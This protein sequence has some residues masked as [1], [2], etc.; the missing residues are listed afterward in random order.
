M[1][2]TIITILLAS[3]ALV[4]CTKEHQKTCRFTGSKRD[5]TYIQ[6][7]F[8]V[9]YLYLGDKDSTEVKVDSTTFTSSQQYAQI[10][11]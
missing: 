10:C 1:K 4:S 7:D 8:Y 5:S 11:Y 6:H 2:K 3:I 9:K